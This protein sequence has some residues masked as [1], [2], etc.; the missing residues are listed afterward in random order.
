MKIKCLLVFLLVI[1]MISCKDNNDDENV[2]AVVKNVSG[3]WEFIL[4]PDHV[5]QDTVVIKGLSDEDF[6]VYPSVL[7]QVYLYQDANGDLLGFA[8]PCKL[9]G[10]ITGAKVILEVYVNPD[11]EYQPELPV[12][13]M[14]LFSEMELI[15]DNYGIMEG[16]GVYL[17]YP[18]YPYMTNNTYKVNAR[19]ILDL[20][21]VSDMAGAG[22]LK[23]WENDICKI[24]FTVSSWI[25]STLTDG[26]VRTMSSDCWLHK[27]GGGYYAFGHQGPGS[28]FPIL[29]QSVYYPFEWSACHVRQ[30]GFNISLGGEN[31][32][33]E[34]LKHSIIDSPPV[35]DLIS[36]LGFT[37][38][39]QLE[40]ALDD[41]YNQYGGFGISMFYD[42]ETHNIGLYVNHEQGNSNDAKN[43]VLVQ[44]MAGAF[45]AFGG[46]V[47]VYAG[48]SIN[49]NWHLRRSPAFICNTPIII[50]YVIGTNNVYYN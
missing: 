14:A 24:I 3:E 47:Y 37:G 18:E 40:Q 25:I 49:D 23:S 42:T 38:V 1:S 50:C 20:K 44:S 45:D 12:E 4:V 32:S 22:Q 16:S 7:N 11:G 5:F 36:K 30:Y 9:K 21:D 41:F 10:N 8:G 13:N 48:Q 34:V 35:K 2:S 15:V 43:S 39:P 31:I 19:K 46:T 17:S 28:L 29:T 33:Y 6:E 27:D 26:I